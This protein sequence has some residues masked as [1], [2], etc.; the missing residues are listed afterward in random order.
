MMF[1]FLFGIWFNVIVVEENKYNNIIKIEQYFK[2]LCL[3][4]YMI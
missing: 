2:F 1:F 4:Y 3:W